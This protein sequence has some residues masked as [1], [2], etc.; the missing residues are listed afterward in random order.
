MGLWGYND[1]RLYARPVENAIYMLCRLVLKLGKTTA[2]IGG[3]ACMCWCQHKHHA[4]FGVAVNNYLVCR[5]ETCPIVSGLWSGFSEGDGAHSGYM[6]L[7][8]VHHEH[9]E[10][11]FM[12]ACKGDKGAATVCI[13]SD[14]ICMC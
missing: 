10:M 7:I 8:H 5:T 6:Q 12:C 11:K 4:K 1:H 9:H 14:V 13:A 2:C 3:V